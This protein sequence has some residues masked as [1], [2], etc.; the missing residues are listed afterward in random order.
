MYSGLSSF[1]SP[2]FFLFQIFIL[3]FYVWFYFYFDYLC[4]KFFTKKK[5]KKLNRKLNQY[6]RPK[7]K[8]KSN[9]KVQNNLK[10]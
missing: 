8:T 2:S 6:E 7:I 9:I 1:E 10:F 3:T 5:K 4:F